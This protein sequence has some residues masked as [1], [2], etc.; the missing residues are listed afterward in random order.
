MPPRQT[1]Y[2]QKF[3]NDQNTVETLKRSKNTIETSENDQ[4]TPI[5]SKNSIDSLDFWGISVGFELFCSYYRIFWHFAHFSNV[6]GYILF[7]LDVWGILVIFEILRFDC[8]ILV[9]LELSGLFK[10]F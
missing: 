6:E 2:P 9:T 5:Q 10:S 4:N 3:L 8:C 7:I 1:Q